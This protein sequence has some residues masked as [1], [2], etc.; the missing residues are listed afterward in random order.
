MATT[1]VLADDEDD[2]RAV[3][4][5]ALRALGYTVWEAARG[6]DAVA[7]VLEHRPGLLLLDVWMPEM[8]G[9]EVLERLRHDP[10]AATMKVV[11][12][13]NMSDADT[14]M[15]CFDRGATDYWI[16]GLPLA[17]LRDR[18]ALLLESGSLS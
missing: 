14:R 11:M 9:L 2:I 13:S 1:I 6:Q 4:A 7:L 15:E 5:P 18:V 10:A 8:S 3:Y 17:D 16:K 12:L